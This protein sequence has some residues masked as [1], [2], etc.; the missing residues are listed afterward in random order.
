MCGIS[1]RQLR[2]K[3]QILLGWKCIV[4]A[5][6]WLIDE[7]FSF[8]SQGSSQNREVLVIFEGQQ[9]NR[10][11]SRK[12]K[13]TPCKWG[14]SRRWV[15]AHLIAVLVEGSTHCNN[16]GSTWRS[17]LQSVSRVTPISSY[18]IEFWGTPVRPGQQLSFEKQHQGRLQF[19]RKTIQAGFLELRVIRVRTRSSGRRINELQMPDTSLRNNFT[20]L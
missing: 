15:L 18:L 3:F 9:F 16:L 5:S 13:T 2:V 20:L 12:S 1:Y 14:R 8:Q 10:S 17:Q 19:R 7:V 4:I 6:F 11:Q